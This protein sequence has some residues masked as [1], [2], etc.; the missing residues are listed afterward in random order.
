MKKI[1]VSLILLVSIIFSNTS[2]SDFLNIVPE[3]VASMDNAFSNRANSERYLMTCYSYLPNFSSVNNSL[4]FLAGDEYWVYAKGTGSIS[5][6]LG[7]LDCWEIGRGAQNSNAPYMNYWEGEK[8][9]KSLW[10]GIR[11]CNIFL[12]N[13]H[14]PMDVQEYE[15]MRWI[16]EVKLWTK[17]LM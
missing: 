3:G 8:S 13:I 2:C 11:D 15:R 1:L 10:K 14:K 12:E 16:A 6:R 7:G 4:G 5:D 9:A 17:T